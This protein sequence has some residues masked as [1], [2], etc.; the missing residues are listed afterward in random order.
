[1]TPSARLQAVVD[2]LAGL[3]KTDQPADRYLRD[4]FRARR[5]AGSKDRAAVA[6]RVFAIFRHRFSLAW[7]MGRDDPRSLVIASLLAEGQTAEEIESLFDGVHYGPAVL[8]DDERRAIASPP[9]DP[10]L[11]V[12]GEFPPFLEVDLTRAF[13]ERLLDEMQAMR[14]RAPIDLRVNTL[15]ASRDHVA[16]AL[17]VQGFA[18]DPTPFSPWGL[19][20]PPGEGSAKLGAT[21]LF[22]DGAFEFQDEGAQIAVLLCGVRPGQ[23]VLDYAAGAGGKSLALAAAMQNKG[24][25]VA[26]DAIP[27]R[28]HTLAPRAVRAAATII[29]V[30]PPERGRL[31]GGP[32]HDP[33]PNALRAL[34]PP[35]AG[36]ENFDL[37]LVDVPCSGTGT[38]RRQPELRWRLTPTRL[39]ELLALQDKLL[40]Q[41]AAFVAP[42]G[43]LVYVT[44]S[45]LPRE[46]DDRIAAFTADH[47]DFLVVSAADAWREN[48]QRIPP[49][50][51]GRLFHSVPPAT[52][53]FF[54]AIMQR[55][56]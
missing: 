46:N 55:H 34:D 8:G 16:D 45:V 23:R 42:G 40:A 56:R 3:E 54:T 24:D 48:V 2:V 7:R 11:N 37:V 28:L 50:G 19:R 43:R 14:A 25:I 30:P 44:C 38:W 33:S 22:A 39:A 4:F 36:E 53:G 13:G 47:P 41:A 49:P 27:E 52:D 26:H 6:E 10:P 20:L 32:Q 5:Y 1:L 29:R 18:V 51:L 12:R 9:A 31:G 21:A 35:L 17:R 15:K